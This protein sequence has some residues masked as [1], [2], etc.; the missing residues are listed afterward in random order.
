MRRVMLTCDNPSCERSASKSRSIA[1][2]Y[3][4]DS[5]PKG[6]LHLRSIVGNEEM[7][8]CCL[9]CAIDILS[10]RRASLHQISFQ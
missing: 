7:E 1:D 10:R 8:V 2:L 6:W 3:P 9:E 5:R 4:G